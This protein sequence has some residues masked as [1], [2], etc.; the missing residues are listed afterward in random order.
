VEIV[1]I[2][3]RDEKTKP[4]AL[5]TL[6]RVLTTSLKLLHPM[7]PFITEDLFL[8]L[9]DAEETIMLSPWPLY[10]PDLADPAAEKDMERVKEAVRGVRNI[11]SEKQVPPSQRIAITI[12]PNDEAAETLF[13]AVKDFIGFLCGASE[14]VAL[15]HTHTETPGGEAVS[16]V[17]SGAAFY[18][19]LAS[20]VDSEKEKA[21]LAKERQRLT[22][23]LAR[24]D[25]KLA[26]EGFMAKAPESLIASE[27]EK[28]GNFAAMLARVEAE[29]GG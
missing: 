18:L 28:R 8:A 27:R 9:Q 21:R 7:T 2:R 24:I 22:Q 6:I 20:L 16:V 12:Q 26:N 15:P 14:V 19:P 3:L 29:Q 17:V 4:E 13:A 10:D 25:A 23:E 11:R 5:D 1:K